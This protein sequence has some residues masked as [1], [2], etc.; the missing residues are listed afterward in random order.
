[1]FSIKLL[2]SEKM[3]TTVDND[4]A[5]EANCKYVHLIYPLKTSIAS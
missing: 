1:M 5:N 4:L 3:W 2:K